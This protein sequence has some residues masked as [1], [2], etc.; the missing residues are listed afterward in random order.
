MNIFIEPSHARRLGELAAM[1]GLSKSAVVGA[2]LSAFLAPESGDAQ[3]AMVGRR[4]DRLN[5]QFSRLERDQAIL[6]E[7]V[8]LYVRYFLTVSASV[9]DGHQT[10]ARAQGKARFEQFVEQLARHV[11]R[12]R[13]LVDDVRDRE[14]ASSVPTD[15]PGH[16]TSSNPASADLS[17]STGVTP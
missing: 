9:P 7:T 12:G 11:R 5:S 10:A 2:A 15:V 6:I 13:S 17:V 16:A 14:D 4:L 3:R 8:A 1:K